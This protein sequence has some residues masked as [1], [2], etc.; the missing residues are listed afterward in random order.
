MNLCFMDL[1][2]KKRRSRKDRNYDVILEREKVKYKCTYT[3]H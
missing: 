1:I 3:C 2:I